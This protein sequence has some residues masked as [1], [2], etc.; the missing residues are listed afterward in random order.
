MKRDGRIV[1]RPVIEVTL[2]QKRPADPRRFERVLGR[3]DAL[4]RTSDLA[5]S[6]HANRAV[7]EASTHLKDQLNRPHANVPLALSAL[8]E[9]V[10]QW[11][12]RS[13]LRDEH[14][15]KQTLD[16]LLRS[17]GVLQHTCLRS[18]R[19]GRPLGADALA[20]CKTRAQRHTA[21]LVLH[22]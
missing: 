10:A 3:L 7:L 20:A 11:L 1:W 17:M 12:H 21:I 16:A 8:E 9:Q 19:E 22:Q 5:R 13:H 2:V 15:R 6:A 14:A 18:L 4:I